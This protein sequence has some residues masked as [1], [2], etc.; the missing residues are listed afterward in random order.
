MKRRVAVIYDG[1]IDEELDKKIAKVMESIGCVWYA[2]GFDF[3]NCERD[4]NFDIED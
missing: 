4:L 2:Q 1:G 3:V